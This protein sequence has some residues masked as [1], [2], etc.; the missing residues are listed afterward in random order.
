MESG[1]RTKLTK[2]SRTCA[3]TLAWGCVDPKIPPEGHIICADFPVDVSHAL[4]AA[5]SSTIDTQ[6]AAVRQYAPWQSSSESSDIGSYEFAL[7]LKLIAR[8][9]CT[10]RIHAN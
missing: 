7:L 5:V 2:R 9:S 3:V 6:A 1:R 10:V 8:L 4:L